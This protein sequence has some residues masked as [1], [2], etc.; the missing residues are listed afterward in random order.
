MLDKTTN[1]PEGNYIRLLQ[2]GIVEL[3]TNGR[4]VVLDAGMH[5][6][7]RDSKEED[8]EDLA[9]LPPEGSA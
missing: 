8:F 2:R 6:I 9:L 5:G 4:D 1:S 7:Q 3:L